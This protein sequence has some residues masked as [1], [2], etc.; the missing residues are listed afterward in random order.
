MRAARA[1]IGRDW[2]E[3]ELTELERLVDEGDEPG[4]VA[5]LSAMVKEPHRVGTE[6]VLEDT[7]H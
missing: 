5:K 1:V 3:E 2:L 4:V 6:G 7:L